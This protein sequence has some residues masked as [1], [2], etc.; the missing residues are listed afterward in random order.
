MRA[1]GRRIGDVQSAIG[2]GARAA[3]LLQYTSSVRLRWAATASSTRD[4]KALISGSMRS[5]RPRRRTG[6]TACLLRARA[7]GQLPAGHVLQHLSVP[8]RVR[9]RQTHAVRDAGLRFRPRVSWFWRASNGW[10]HGFKRAGN[11]DART[12]GEKELEL[13]K[14]FE[15]CHTRHALQNTRRL[16]RFTVL[17]YPRHEFS[18]TQSFNYL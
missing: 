4:N 1:T 2:E 12:L 11:V 16:W 18:W 10:W 8:P 5:R 9:T 6:R 7:G 14:C 17:S 13:I 15:N 3:L